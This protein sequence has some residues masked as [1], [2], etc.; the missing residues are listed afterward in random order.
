MQ[1]SSSEQQNTCA[2]IQFITVH[3]GGRGMDD[4]AIY[5]WCGHDLKDC[6]QMH[7][8]S[9]L[10]SFILLSGLLSMMRTASFTSNSSL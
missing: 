2:I 1:Q 7:E 3:N 10:V 5:I 4:V 8:I 6:S 9:L